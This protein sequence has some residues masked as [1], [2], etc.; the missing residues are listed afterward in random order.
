MPRGCLRQ[1]SHLLT[2]ALGG[3]TPTLQ[4]RKW[5]PSEATWMDQHTAE[6]RK[7]GPTVSPEVLG[8]RRHTAL[9]LELITG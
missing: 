3:L 7:A 9:A 8:S 6:A 5:R 4:T 1:H 2:A